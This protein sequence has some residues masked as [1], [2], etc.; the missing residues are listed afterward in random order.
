MRL[1]SV[2]VVAACA[3][4]PPTPTAPCPAPVA[5]VPSEDTIKRR[6][7]DVLTAYDKGDLAAFEGAITADFVHFEGGE[8][9]LRKDEIERVKKR[10]PGMPTIGERTW[11]KEQVIVHPGSILFVGKAL[12]T[13]S[14]NE[15]HGG[16]KY[17]GWYAVQWVPDGGDWKVRLVTWHVA[18]DRAQA[19]SWNQIYR[20]GVGFTHEPNRLLVTTMTG[21]QP[22]TA[23]DLAMGQGRNALYLA[24][25][26][27]KVTGVDIADAGIRQAR[28]EAT[29]RKLALDTVE[30]NA[31]RWDFGTN[32][33]DLITMIYAGNRP[34]WMDKI[35]AGLKPNGLFVL[36]FFAYDPATGQDDGFKPGELA[37]VFGDGYEIVKDEIVED[38][39]DWA[40]NRAKLQRFIARKK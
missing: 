10:K 3:G 38:V 11:D 40:M 9:S 7:H 1:A 16:Y 36:E 23:L 27:W 32:R 21:K 35:K 25:Q 34:A 29:R 2:L 8:P 18:G 20:N 6:S 24:S 26:G 31:D 15:V 13:Q 28:E 33:W 12:E 22:G 4:R 30:A 19:D 37:K 39:P 14:G 17:E 5:A